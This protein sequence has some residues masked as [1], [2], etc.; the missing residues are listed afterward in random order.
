MFVVLVEDDPYIAESICASLD[1]LNISV[2][3]VS[4]A[5]DADYFVRHSAVDLCLLDLGLPDQ[6]GLDLLKK[7]RSDQIHTPVLVLTARLQ[8]QQCVEALNLGA[9]DYLTKPFELD[10]LIARIHALT[11]R[12][13]GFSSNVIQFEGLQLNKDT[14]EVSYQ[15]QVIQL[16]RREYSLLET[17]MSHPNQVLKNEV[18]LDKLYGFQDSIESNALNVHIYHLRQKLGADYIQTVRG[19]GYMFKVP[20]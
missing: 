12:H 14:Q 11:R 6:D 2:E 13:R 4:N 20:E 10:E 16:S 19:V 15:A 9:D 3:H 8:T 1:F 18:L 5:R 17:L 7:W